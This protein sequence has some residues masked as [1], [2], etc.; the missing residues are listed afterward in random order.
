MAEAL[1][2]SERFVKEDAR[3]SIFAPRGASLEAS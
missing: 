3:N 1:E 2:N